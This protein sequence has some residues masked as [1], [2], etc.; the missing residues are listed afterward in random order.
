VFTA[1]RRT[2]KNLL[3]A[4]LFSALGDRLALD[5][6]NIQAQVNDRG[7]THRRADAEGINPR[8]EW[9]NIGLVQTA[10]D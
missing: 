4:R 8:K 2:R 1:T 7:I 9:R 5:L 3:P 10:R 6:D